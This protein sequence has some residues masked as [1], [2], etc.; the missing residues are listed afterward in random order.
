MLVRLSASIE[1]GT[2][3]F[4]AEEQRCEPSGSFSF[5]EKSMLRKVGEEYLGINGVREKR[6]HMV[7]SL[8]N[9]GSRT[10]VPDC[11]QFTSAT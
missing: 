9:S 11:S 1:G 2:T 3:K 7:S 10:A 4:T 6:I 5:D 8:L